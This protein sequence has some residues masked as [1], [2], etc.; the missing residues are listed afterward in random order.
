MKP[1]ESF[2]AETSESEHFKG[3][4]VAY[5]ECRWVSDAPSVPADSLTAAESETN[6]AA[7]EAPLAASVEDSEPTVSEAASEPAVGEKA[8][9][10]AEREE[11]THPRARRNI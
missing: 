9:E 5:I 7:F 3:V 11:L 8:S 10:P 1:H 2:I 4:G 6:E